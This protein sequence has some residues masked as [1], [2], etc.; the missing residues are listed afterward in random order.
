[1]RWKGR[2][3]KDF[4]QRNVLILQHVPS[5]TLLSFHFLCFVV[6]SLVNSQRD[7]LKAQFFLLLFFSIQFKNKL[8]VVSIS[9]IFFLHFNSH[10]NNHTPKKYSR[11]RDEIKIYFTLLWN[12]IGYIYFYYNVDM[13]NGD[14]E[15]CTITFT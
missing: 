1:M 14:G 9:S 15:K 3:K 6:V 4:F 2:R 12:S 7:P 13:E 10:T 8:H 5:L 11:I